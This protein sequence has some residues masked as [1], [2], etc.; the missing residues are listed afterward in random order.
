MT[1]DYKRNGPINLFAA[2]KVAT[3][4]VLTDLRK[5]PHR[6]RRAAVIQ[7]D[8]RQRSTRFGCAR[9]AGPRHPPPNQNA[10]RPL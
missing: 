7:T 2:M 4:E 6:R 5:G 9:R 10:D 3:G 8:R 1:H